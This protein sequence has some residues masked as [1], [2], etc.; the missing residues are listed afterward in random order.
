VIV[1]DTNVWARS[2]LNDDANQAAIA[3]DAL[4]RARASGGVFVPLL[5][6]AELAWVLRA[7]WNRKSI[8][9]VL[10]ILLNTQGVAVEFPAIVSHA[11]KAARDG[12]GGFP[13]HLIAQVGLAN[14]ASETL[15]FDESF[16][17]AANVRLLR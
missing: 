13:D 3:H 6:L 8:L 5:V 4:T 9:D 2:L 11:I 10:E 14:G 15:T 12:K 1:A 16:G 7:R 17:K